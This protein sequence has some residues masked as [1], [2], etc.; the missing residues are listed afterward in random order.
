VPHGLFETRMRATYAP[1]WFSYDVT[2]DGQRFLIDA[3]RPETGPSI[4]LVVNWSPAASR[5]PN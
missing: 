4:S 2:S 1:Y 5:D 3:V